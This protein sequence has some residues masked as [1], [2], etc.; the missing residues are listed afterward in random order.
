MPAYGVKRDTTDLE[1]LQHS[2]PIDVHEVVHVVVPTECNDYQNWQVTLVI[3]FS[4]S[5]DTLNGC[6]HN[7]TS[8][9]AMVSWS[10]V[11]LA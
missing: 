1:P 3:C 8:L 9:S 11:Y 6:L 10:V 2:Y 4:D 7:M 5:N